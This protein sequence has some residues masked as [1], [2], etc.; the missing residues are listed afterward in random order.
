M[1]YI[2]S[3]NL[4][5]SLFKWKDVNNFIDQHI[6]DIWLEMDDYL[7]PDFNK[8]N[9]QIKIKQFDEGSYGSRENIPTLFVNFL[10]SDNEGIDMDDVRKN[11][12]GKHIMSYSG[13]TGGENTPLDVLKNHSCYNDLIDAHNHTLSTL[14][15]PPFDVFMMKGSRDPWSSNTNNEKTIYVEI[16]Y[17]LVEQF[18]QAAEVEINRHAHLLRPSK[19]QIKEFPLDDHPVVKKLKKMQNIDNIKDNFKEIYRDLLNYGFQY[20]H[21]IDKAKE[22]DFEE[23]IRA[24]CH[25]PEIFFVMC[26]TGKYDSV[27]YLD[28]FSPSY[29]FYTGSNPESNL[30]YEVLLPMFKR[31]IKSELLWVEGDSEERELAVLFL[32]MNQ[33]LLRSHMENGDSRDRWMEILKHSFNGV[34]ENL[35]ALNR[36]EAFEWLVSLIKSEEPDEESIKSVKNLLDDF[37]VHLPRIRRDFKGRDRWHAPLTSKGKFKEVPDFEFFESKINELKEYI[38]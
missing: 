8:G 17:K 38:A 33:T 14:S 35:L 25:S 16:Q 34:A 15:N 37:E 20:K 12:K 26:M 27:D 18:L 24:G 9:V 21:V 32:I 7:Y 30:G 2:S 6:P 22:L 4:F 1:K 31:C 19:D 13:Q 5:E 29:F 28:D 11:N 10:L 23:C 36:K 3:Y